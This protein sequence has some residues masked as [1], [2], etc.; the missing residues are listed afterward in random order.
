MSKFVAGPTLPRRWQ[1]GVV[2][3]GGGPDGFLEISGVRSQ[4]GF[5]EIGLRVP[6]KGRREL[7]GSTP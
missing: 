3:S 2:A 1:S 7:T 5:G 6:M 4:T